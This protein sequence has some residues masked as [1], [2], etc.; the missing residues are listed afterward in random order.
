MPTATKP[1]EETVP[2]VNDEIAV[3]ADLEFQKKWWRFEFCAWVFFTLIVILDLLGAFGRG[4]LAKARAQASDDSFNIAYERVERFGTPS[5]LTVHFAQ[6]A[7]HDGKVQLWASGNLVKELGAQRVVPQ[8][9][10]SVLA[11]GGILYSFPTTAIPASAE[12][13]L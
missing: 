12:F 7:I 6:S 3:G 13:A 10:E 4:Y 8:P 11:D 9:T 1:V 2:K 5:V